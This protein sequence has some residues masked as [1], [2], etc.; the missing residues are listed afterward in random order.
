MLVKIWGQI[1]KMYTGCVRRKEFLSK[2]I[3]SYY[4]R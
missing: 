3:S 2:P 4:L 1:N